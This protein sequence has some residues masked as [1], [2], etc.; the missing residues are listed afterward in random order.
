MIISFVGVLADWLFFSFFFFLIADARLQ[1]R[2]ARA[3]AGIHVCSDYIAR[4][5]R[6]RA[7]C[8]NECAN[9]REKIVHFLLCVQL[10]FRFFLQDFARHRSDV[11]I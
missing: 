7:H 5:I 2:D 1:L 8:V 6:K 11:I 10:Q 9:G 3:P 4:E